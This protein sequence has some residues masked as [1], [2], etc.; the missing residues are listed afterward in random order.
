VSGK[1]R[2]IEVF[3]ALRFRL[4]FTCSGWWLEVGSSA[5]VL[6]KFI[7]EVTTVTILLVIISTFS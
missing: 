3:L 1:I 6:N 2:F 4:F 7:H 5:L